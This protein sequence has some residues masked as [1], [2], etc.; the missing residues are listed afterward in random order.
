MIIAGNDSAAKSQVTEILRSFG[1]NGAID[2]G[3]IES[4]RWLEAMV[5]LWVRVASAV[6]TY[7]VA[8]KVVR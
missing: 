6:G 3:G 4:A 1:W 7:Q 8:F 2:I 5:P